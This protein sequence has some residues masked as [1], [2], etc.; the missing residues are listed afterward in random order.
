M[1]T[2]AEI[3]ERA[4]G[5]GRVREECEPEQVDAAVKAIGKV[6]YD[7]AEEFGARG[8]RVRHG[9]GGRQDR[10]MPG[11]NQMYLEQPEGQKSYGIIE[12][13]KETGIIKVAKPKGLWAR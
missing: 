8:G 6:V 1:A 10:Q 11:K 5:A 9:R 13:N 12:E 3:F 2:V 4:T 7:R